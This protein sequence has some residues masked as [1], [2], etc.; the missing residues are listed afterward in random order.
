MIDINIIRQNI[1]QYET[2]KLCEMIVSQRYFNMDPEISIVCMNE[3]SIRRSNGDNFNYEEYIDT[4]SKSLPDLKFKTTD[5]K[6]LIQQI[7][8]KI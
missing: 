2:I 1:N 8:R 7:K 3:L 5:F 4:A 6:D